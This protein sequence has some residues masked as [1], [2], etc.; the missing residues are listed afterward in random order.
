L[1]GVAVAVGGLVVP[2]CYDPKI[3]SG[4]LV[5]AAATGKR[6]PDGFQ[7]TDGVCVSTEGASPGSG[8]AGGNGSGGADGTG[9]AGGS[10]ANPIAPLCEVSGDAPAACDPVCQTGCPCGLLCSVSAEGVGCA[11]P[12]GT[13]A[14]GEICQP[15]SVE[16]GP[17][18]VCNKESCGANLGR[19]YRF[20]R[21][22]SCGGDVVCGT[23]VLLPTGEM[24][25]QRACNLGGHSCDALARTGCPDPAFNCYVTAPSQTTCDC[26]TG[27]ERQDGESCSGYNDCALGLACL[28]VGGSGVSTCHRLCRSSSDCAGCMTLGTAGAF[29]P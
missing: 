1:F 24:T 26:P 9:G 28:E 17:G 20:C 23:P 19:C 3:K 7:C 14:V 11:T 15:G 2:G 25:G 27:R 21:N 8:G 16:C 4:G 6:C 12:L 13:K 10:C 5:C 18:L 22:N 29:C